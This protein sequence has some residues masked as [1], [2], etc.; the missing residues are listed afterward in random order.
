MH[1]YL[2]LRGTLSILPFDVERIPPPAGRFTGD[3]RT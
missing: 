2:V 1:L 3:E